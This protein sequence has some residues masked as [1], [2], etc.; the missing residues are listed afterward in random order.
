MPSRPAEGLTRRTVVRG[1]AWS[2]PVIA[3]SVA[4]PLAAASL[5]TCPALSYW[6]GDTTHSEFSS[7]NG[8]RWTSSS[9]GTASVGMGNTGVPDGYP[10]FSLSATEPVLV[11][12]LALSYTYT[13]EYAMDWTSIPTG[14]TL[15]STSSSGGTWTYVFTYQNV[16]TTTTVTSSTAPGTTIVPKVEVS[17]SIIASSI[18]VGTDVSKYRDYTVTM[19]VTYVP[20]FTTSTAC[21]STDGDDGSV[22]VRQQTTTR[23]IK[24][25]F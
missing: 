20:H 16:G 15:S 25:S 23:P 4:V 14:W 7:L 2:V 9:T 6:W 3:A 17:G 18:P 24:S 10:A 12:L 8:R 21:T 22:R 19:D 5:T 11:D 1:A 13:L